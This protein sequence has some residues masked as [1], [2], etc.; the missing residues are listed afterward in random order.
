MVHESQ[1]RLEALMGQAEQSAN[2]AKVAATY[3]AESKKAR[4][5]VLR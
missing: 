2:D 4:V 1:G 5:G 3:L